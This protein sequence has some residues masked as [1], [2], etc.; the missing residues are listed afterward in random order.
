MRGVEIY[1]YVALWI[2]LLFI[3]VAVAGCTGNHQSDDMRPSDEPMYLCEDGT[4][5]DEYAADADQPDCPND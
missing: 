5:I 4:P 3:A 2:I 1:V